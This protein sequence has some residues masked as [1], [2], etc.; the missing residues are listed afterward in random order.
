MRKLLKKITDK[1]LSTSLNKLDKID[2]TLEN[3]VL[4]KSSAS[5]QISLY[6]LYRQL[7]STQNSQ[8]LSFQEVGFR[9]YSQHEEDGILLYIFAIIGITNKKCIEV[10]AGDG[11]ECNTTN[12]ILNHRW[13]GYLFDGNLENVKRG[14]DFFAKH[15]DSKYYPPKFVHAWITKDNINQLILDAGVKGDIDL[16]SLD[17]DG[18]DYWLLNEI[19]VVNPRVIVLEINHLWGDKEAV[20]T[21]YDDNFVAEFSKYGSDYAGASLPAFIKLCR[22]KGYRLVG[23]NA[24]ATNAFFVRNDIVHPWLPEIEANQCFNHPRAQFGMETRFLGI[25]DKNWVNV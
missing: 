17:I 14:I 22:E 24:I 1:F 10:C 18:N 21:P 3:K 6:V 23:T 25:K 12:L 20:T 4:R 15:P 19:S 16:L 8:K 11:L 13:I 7:V 2:N 5:T 9:E